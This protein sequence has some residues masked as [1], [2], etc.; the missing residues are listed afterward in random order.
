M[1]GNKYVELI[2]TLE[3][4]EVVRT[5]VVYEAGMAQIGSRVAH[6]YG[7]DLTK[8]GIK[9]ATVLF[10]FFRVWLDHLTDETQMIQA[11][12]NLKEEQSRIIAP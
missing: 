6:L 4:P 3:V 7:E 9:A 2:K 8:T 10:A 1:D 11:M 5:T 12:D